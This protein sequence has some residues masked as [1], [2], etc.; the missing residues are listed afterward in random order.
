MVTEAVFVVTESAKASIRAANVRLVND[1]M[2]EADGRPE[3]VDTTGGIVVTENGKLRG[4]GH[5]VTIKYF[6]ND[7]YILIEVRLENYPAFS[8]EVFSAG[9]ED[10]QLREYVLG[11]YQVA[12]GRL[13][14][15]SLASV[16]ITSHDAR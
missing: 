16:R 13:A 9:V 4:N 1:I 15:Q 11:A 2:L 7:V 5:P 10:V 3:C 6:Q 8:M 12:V 14:G